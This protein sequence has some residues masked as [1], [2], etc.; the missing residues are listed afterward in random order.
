[1]IIEHGCIV[2]VNPAT[3]TVIARVP[4]STASEIDAA[5]AGARRAQPGWAALPLKARAEAVK[6]AVHRLQRDRA[7]LARLITTEMGKVLRE[8]EA[9]VDM[10]GNKV[11]G[12]AS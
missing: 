10:A 11:T 6:A 3:G 5:V 1:V 8:A 12:S 4:V 2:D 7:G 9:E